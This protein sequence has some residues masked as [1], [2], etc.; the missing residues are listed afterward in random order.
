MCEIDH[1][2]IRGQTGS[3]DNMQSSTASAL[4]HL[5]TQFASYYIR[6]YVV[7]PPATRPTQQGGALTG[8]LLHYGVDNVL[9]T[10]T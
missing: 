7:E 5:V 2:N 6:L 3:F 8:C 10:L 4:H 1:E 9:S